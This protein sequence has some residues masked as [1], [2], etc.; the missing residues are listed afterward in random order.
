MSA[1]F[2]LQIEAFDVPVLPTLAR[3]RP[4]PNLLPASDTGV[5]DEDDITVATTL[6]FEVTGL[7]AGDAVQCSC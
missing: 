1:E 6:Q 3:C 4:P 2:H 7:V 5:S